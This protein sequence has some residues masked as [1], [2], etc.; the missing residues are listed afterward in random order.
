[1]ADYTGKTIQQMNKENLKRISEQVAKRQQESAERFAKLSNGLGTAFSK[2]YD[3]AEVT[4]TAKGLL[5]GKID[6]KKMG[7]DWCIEYTAICKM[8][9]KDQ[10]LKLLELKTSAGMAYLQNRIE[11]YKKLQ[12]EYEN[13]DATIN[14]LR[15]FI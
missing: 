5:E 3:L 7:K 6:A 9:I 4:N 12:Q 13:V 11:S 8:A 2:N 15:T 1:M 10:D 14:L